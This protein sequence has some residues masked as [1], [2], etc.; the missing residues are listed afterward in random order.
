MAISLRKGQ[1]VSLT[2][3]NPSLKKIM[4]GLGWMANDSYSDYDFD[5]DASVLLCDENGTCRDMSDVVYFGNLKHSSG[6]VIHRGDNLV[7]SYNNEQND[8]EQIMVN[9]S[10]IPQYI[11]KLVFIVTIY[12]ADERGQNFGDVSNAFIRLVDQSTDKE[13]IRYDLTEDFY[14]ETAVVVGE[15]YL[16][17]N[18]WKFNAIGNGFYGGMSELLSHYGLVVGNF[19]QNLQ[20]RNSLELTVLNS[21]N[22]L[23]Q[24]DDVQ[25]LI[26]MRTLDD[27]QF[28]EL[29]SHVFKVIEI[30]ANKINELSD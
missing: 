21:I 13:L 7:G 10:K 15:I 12:K 27:S 4:V 19:N 9:L 26:M 30:F 24:T 18:E 29:A 1:K 3:N 23:K 28:A 14:D 22:V 6:A 25:F 8:D 20:N 5:L 17:K 2:K 16:Y 11:K